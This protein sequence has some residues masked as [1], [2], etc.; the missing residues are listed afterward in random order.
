MQAGGFDVMQ[1]A[2]TMKARSDTFGEREKAYNKERRLKKVKLKMPTGTVVRLAPD[3]HNA[4][5]VAVV[6]E[7]GPRFAPGA[8][9]L[10][11]GN[12]TKKHLICETDQL[13][14]L[15]SDITD[16]EKLPDIV[17]HEPEKSRLF[18]IEA[19]TSHGPVDPKRREE[20]ESMFALCPAHRI[21]VTA[22]FE[23]TDLSTY[24]DDIAWE[25]EVWFADTPDH[26][27]HF[28]GKRTRLPSGIWPAL[29]DFGV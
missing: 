23:T 12:A 25:T 26:M 27:I 19:V 11:M 24:L 14:A 7:F 22:L 13:A 8:T 21:Y 20:L 4:L 2:E 6:E 5:Q 18:L 10:Y 17:L 16:N 28:N 15:R 1:G 29:G 9:L 3:K